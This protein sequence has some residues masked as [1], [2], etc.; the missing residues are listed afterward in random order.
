MPVGPVELERLVTMLEGHGKFA[1]QGVAVA[2]GIQGDSLSDAVA[3]GPVE[4]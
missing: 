4:P 1:Q 3:G 2:Q